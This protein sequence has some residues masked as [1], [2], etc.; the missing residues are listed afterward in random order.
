[1]NG[2]A[3]GDRDVEGHDQDQAVETVGV[4]ELGM[5]KPRDLKSENIGSIPQ[6]SAYSRVRK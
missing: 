4:A 2:L 3:G 5:P 1:M 6:R